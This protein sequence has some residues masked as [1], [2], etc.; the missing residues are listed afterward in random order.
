[1]R[2]CREKTKICQKFCRFVF[3]FVSSQTVTQQ[4]IKGMRNSL[5]KRLTI[6]ITA[7]VLV[8]LAIITSLVYI[9]VKEYMLEEAQERYLGVMLDEYEEI[10]RRLSDIYVASLN[11]IHEIERDID[12]PDLMAEHVERFVINNKNIA[13]CGLLFIP[14]YYPQ[15][16]RFFVSFAYRDSTGFVGVKRIDSVYN[17]YSDTDWFKGVIQ[18]DKADW[19]GAYFEDSTV[20]NYSNPRLLTT[21]SSPVHNKQRQP[22]AVL[23]VDFSLERLNQKLK[24]KVDLVNQ[25]FEKG[26]GHKSYGFIIDSLGTYIIHPDKKRMLKS[27]IQEHFKD[28]LAARK[29]LSQMEKEKSGSW[30][31]DVEGVPSWVFYRYVKFVKWYFVIVVPEVA[32]VHNGR[33]LNA[34]IL[35][36]IFLGLMVIFFTCRYMIKQTTKPLHRFALSADQVAQGNFTSPLPEIKDYDEVRLL[37]DAFKNM[38]SSLVV[39]V[40]E[41]QRTTTSKASLERELKIASGI[42]MAMLP[43]TFLSKKREEL[44][45]YAS[46]TAARDVGGDLY[47]YFLRDNSLFFCIGDVSGKGVPAALMMAVMR[48]M[49]R[50]EARRVNKAAKIV[51]TMN[52][53]LGEEQTTGYFITMF[54][55]VLDLMTGHLDYCN[56]GH[57]APLLA[58]QPLPI[59]PNLPVGSLSDWNYEGQEAQLNVGDMLFLY[60]DGLSEAKNTQ[61]QIMGRSRVLELAQAHFGDT[62]KQLVELMETEVRHYAAGAEQSDDI[63]LMAIKWQ[64]MVLR[65]TASMDEIYKLKPFVLE[66]ARSAGLEEVETKRLRLAME[67]MVANVINHGRATGI[68]LRAKVEKEQ[69][70]VTIDDDGQ[71]FDPTQDSPTDLSIPPDQRP[72]GGLGI[73]LLHNMVDGMGYERKDGHNIL[74]IIKRTTNGYHN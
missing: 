32:I 17:G 61:K 38:Q 69:L 53:N 7:V 35:F 51:E 74:T 41:L 8:M 16:G 45:L 20:F 6:R 30:K 48:S 49:F 55:G 19:T 14:D 22:V 10:R 62:C 2:L 40:D 5:A 46:L 4:I 21:Y 12:H 1:M 36:T 56:A 31:M 72:P 63:T 28:S 73:I 44:D 29:I 27:N 33:M 66:A 68:T 50:S 23:C 58:G 39:Y 52:K 43:K 59:K 54:V 47:D 70:V 60:T 18:K 71:P 11:S 65:M 26:L 34:L 64:G 3:F 57:E 25:K 13:S 15:M 67:E 24:E 42:Q 37:H 9:S